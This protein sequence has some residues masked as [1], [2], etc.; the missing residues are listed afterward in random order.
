[1]KKLHQ[2]KYSTFILI[3]LFGLALTSCSTDNTNSEAIEISEFE[4]QKVLAIDDYSGIV[5]N[6]ITEAF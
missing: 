3:A 5:D 1:M 6:A 2:L 4:V